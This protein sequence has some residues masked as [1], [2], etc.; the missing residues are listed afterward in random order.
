VHQNR[1]HAHDVWHH[2]LAAVDAT[3]AISPIGPTWIV[4]LAALLH[5][6][7]KPRTA[8]PRDDAPAENTFYRH[9]LV[10][11]DMTDQILRRLKLS[12][13]DR[14]HVVGLVKNH[15]FWYAP[16]WS[17]GTVRRFISRVG[18]ESLDDLFALREGDV[19]ARGRG[20]EPADE[21]AELRRRIAVELEQ[22]A[23]LKVSDL[24]IGGADVMRLLSC[25]PG[26][27]VG[28]VLRRLL[29]RVLDDAQ[30]NTYERLE[31]LVPEIAREI[32]APAQPDAPK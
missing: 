3:A 18:T 12:T 5:D 1:F 7:A 14:D 26:P 4:R 27:I 6:V 17:D 16:E 24:A 13:R 32:A 31:A 22:A 29:E 23:A 11:A 19:R 9:E 8:A 2:T 21:V 25:R 20:E 30:L 10:G 15:M 28:E